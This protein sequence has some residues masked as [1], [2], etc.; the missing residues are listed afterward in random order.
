MITLFNYGRMYGLPDASPFVSKAE[1]LLRMSGL[2]YQ[3]N[4]KGFG[5]APKGKLPYIND[6]GTIVSDSTLIRFHLEKQHGINFDAHLT[7][8]R[9]AI[10]WAAERMCEEHLYFALLYNN[11]VIERNFA[12]GPK[13]FFNA[14]PAL[15]RPFV[16]HMVRRK[17]IKQLHAQ[18]MGRHSIDDIY[19]LSSIDIDTLAHLLG[20]APYFGGEQPCGA[21]ATFAAFVMSLLCP[22]FESPLRTTAETHANLRAYAQR[23]RERYFPELSA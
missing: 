1:F 10:V 5:K 3:L 12:A 19:R 2:D 8:E 22:V 16:S 4:A 6:A 18:G 15:I 20:N 14:V 9:K 23:M 13:R 7:P 11:W 17:M 21:D